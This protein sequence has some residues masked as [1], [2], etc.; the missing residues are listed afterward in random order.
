MVR[1]FLSF[2]VL[3]LS[4]VLSATVAIMPVR[5]IDDLFSFAADDGSKSKLAATDYV[6][7]I[8][9]VLTIYLVS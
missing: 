8:T 5:V 9:S 1:A 4:V 2:D 3:K 6:F 7:S